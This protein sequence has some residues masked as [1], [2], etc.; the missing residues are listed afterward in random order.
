VASVAEVKAA[1]DAALQQVSEGQLAVRAAGEKLGEAQQSLAAALEGSGQRVGQ[2]RSQAG[3]GRR[4]PGTRGVHDRATLQP[5][6]SRGPVHLRGPTLMSP[7]FRSS[8]R[9]CAGPLR[10]PPWIGEVRGRTAEPAARRGPNCWRWVRPRSRSAGSRASPRSR[11]PRVDHDS[12]RQRALARPGVPQ[13]RSS[14]R[15]SSRL[16]WGPATAAVDHPTRSS[17]GPRAVDQCRGRTARPRRSAADRSHAADAVGGR[18]ESDHLTGTIPRPAARPRRRQRP[19]GSAC[20]ATPGSP[21][22][23]D[24]GRPRGRVWRRVRGGRPAWAPAP[25]PPTAIRPAGRRDPSGTRPAPGRPAPACATWPAVGYAA[26]LP[27]RGRRGPRT[28]SPSA[29]PGPRRVPEKDPRA[30][31]PHPADY[32]HRRQRWLSASFSNAPAATPLS[33]LD[34]YRTPEPAQCLTPASLSTGLA[35]RLGMA[36][37]SLAGLERE[38]RRGSPAGGGGP[39]VARPSEDEVRG[40]TAA[41]RPGPAR[42]RWRSDRTSSGSGRLAH[43]RQGRYAT[44]KPART[45]KPA[46]AAAPPGGD[47]FPGHPG[48]PVD[49]TPPRAEIGT[50]TDDLPVLVNRSPTT[51]T[52][53]SPAPTGPPWTVVPHHDPAP[54]PRLAPPPHRP[55]RRRTTPSSSAGGLAGFAPLTSGEVLDLS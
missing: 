12:T 16:G 11:A 39:A 35:R 30:S 2:R 37:R 32:G 26:L 28:P 43:P 47:A 24:R 53:R 3:P 45:G 9:N 34:R 51:A 21:G 13:E 50:T 18:P 40:A 27:Q 7:R 54:Y 36:L 31:D 20:A 29:R 55:A 1:I 48:A 14:P 17:P 52:W 44:N 19:T 8:G 23:V 5:P 22:H 10:A 25:S 15:T 4:R 6:S 38:H 41:G 46:P 33:T 49:A 42:P